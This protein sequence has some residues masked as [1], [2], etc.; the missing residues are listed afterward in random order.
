MTNAIGPFPR[1]FDERSLHHRNIQIGFDGSLVQDNMYVYVLGNCRAN[2][3][4]HICGAKY[5]YR[6]GVGKVDYFHGLIRGVP[7]C[8][9]WQTEE[10][11][12]ATEMINIS[13]GYT[14]VRI[15]HLQRRWRRWLHRRSIA[16]PPAKKRRNAI[17]DCS[18]GRTRRTSDR[19]K[20]VTT[21]R[22]CLR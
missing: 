14:V 2:P 3:F 16:P 22:N 11:V 18:G 15:I 12:S 17:G 7:M 19:A 6:F 5:R 13:K 10:T 1:P 20:A 8:Q 9:M 4:Y 21:P